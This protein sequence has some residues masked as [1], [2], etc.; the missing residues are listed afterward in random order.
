MK[1]KEFI[2]RNFLFLIV[3]VLLLIMFIQ[4]CGNGPT[5]PSTRVDTVVKY[6]QQ[7]PVYI[8]KYVPVP[9]EVKDRD[10]VVIKYLPSK[11][12]DTLTQQYVDLVRAHLAVKTYK[13]SVGLKDSSGKDVGTVHINDEVSEN[14]IKSRKVDYQLRF[15][16][17]TI[18]I[19]E[20]IKPRNQLYI[21]GGVLG[22]QNR[23]ITGAK[24]GLYLKNKKDQLYGVS[25]HGIAN[26]PLVFSV[27]SYW[28]ISFKKKR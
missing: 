3:I 14:E 9:S 6:I 25:L 28:K 20:P 16:Q 21:G 22:E 1:I 2:N 12:K 11:D 13:D 18:T 23:L 5:P 17:T 26:Y 24:A 10:T 8:P 19:R 15:P 27:E 4:R 7:P